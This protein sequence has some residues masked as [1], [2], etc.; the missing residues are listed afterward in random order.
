[1]MNN[2]PIFFKNLMSLHLIVFRHT[3]HTT[4]TIFWSVYL[5]S[6]ITCINSFLILRDVV[7]LFAFVHRLLNVSWYYPC[8]LIGHTHVPVLA[9]KIYIYF[10][11]I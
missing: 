2:E 11:I 8:R 3:T 1:M 6:N 10:K 5:F 7:L 9:F 4:N